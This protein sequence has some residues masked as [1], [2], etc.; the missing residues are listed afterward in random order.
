[1]HKYSR[2]FLATLHPEVRNIVLSDPDRGS[3]NVPD[4]IREPFGCQVMTS[5]GQEQET[6]DSSTD[7]LIRHMK[8]YV[9]DLSAWRGKYN[10]KRFKRLCN[11]RRKDFLKT[12][13]PEEYITER[14]TVR[15]YKK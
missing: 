10:A 14:G 3:Q 8:F 13:I 2:E 9:R 15:K 1:M 4:Y 7:A 12:Y 11:K 6:G 5:T